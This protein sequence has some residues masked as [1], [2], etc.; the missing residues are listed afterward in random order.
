MHITDLLSAEQVSCQQDISSKKRA[1]QQIAHLLT[2]N[3][4]QIKEDDVF[5]SLLE[6]ERLGSTGLGHG[7]AIPHGRIASTT[8]AS[9][10]VIRL[11]KG[12]D[13]DS[14]DGEPVDI[15]IGLI[16]PEHSTS[17]HLEILACLADILASEDT[18]NKLRRAT[19][20]KA[21][22]EALQAWKC[23]NAA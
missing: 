23:S 2:E 19:S 12:I 15:L 22:M 9:A 10:A 1:L 5:E 7:V 13:Y 20:D 18:R 16:V 17:E 8:E 21:L 6:R 11:D 3:H 4:P 14:P